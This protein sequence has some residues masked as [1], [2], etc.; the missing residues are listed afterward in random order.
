MLENTSTK[1]I[2]SRDSLFETIQGI[3]DYSFL[4]VSLQNLWRYLIAIGFVELAIQLNLHN[5]AFHHAPTLLL[6]AAVI[7]ASWYGGLG[8][9]LFA[10]ALAA[11]SLDYFFIPPIGSLT[12]GIEYVPRS[13]V[14]G[15]VVILISSLV[16]AQ[17]SAEAKIRILA[18]EQ[19]RFNADA[20]HELFTPLS[21]MKTQSEVLLANPYGTIADYNKLTVSNLEEVD[22]MSKI[23]EDLLE[24]SRGRQERVKKEPIELQEIV[25]VVIQKVRTLADKKKIALTF[26]RS[27]HG[28]VLADK[29]ALIP[30]IMNLIQNAIQYTNEGGLVAVNV[31]DTGDGIQFTVKDNGIGIAKENLPQLFNPFYKVDQNRTVGGPGLGLS[32][33]KRIAD[34]YSAKIKIDSMLKV[35]TT[36]SVT[37]PVV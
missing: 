27:D 29:S 2:K 11:L 22:Y 16:E 20:S 7:V 23:V 6:F 8:P 30:M 24:L 25:R 26:Q 10:T 5:R 31:I 37:F 13:T 19:K 14:F 32:I 4:P 15:A 17:R 35:G 36:I 18:E 33:V 34:L 21:V 12:L 9:G 3:R 28:R 1:F